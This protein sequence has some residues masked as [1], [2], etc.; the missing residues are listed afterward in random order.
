MTGRPRVVIIGGGFAGLGVAR[1]LRRVPV[2]IT[3][4]DR[5]NFHL[6]QPLLYQVATGGLSPAN[7]SAPLRSV[8]K[9]QRHTRVI[10][11]EAIDVDLP[12]R[13]VLLPGETLEY[14]TLVVATGTTHHYFGHDEWEHLA[15]GL[16]SIED[17]TEMRRR[18]L[19]AFETAER[20]HTP[21]EMRELLTFV[22]VGGGPTG[23]ELAGAIAEIA[24]DTLHREFRSINPAD[25][26]ILLLEGTDRVLPSYPPNLSH[27]ARRQLEQLGVTVR[28]GAMV[29]EI[30]P[31]QVMIQTHDQSET[32]ATRTVLWAA[33]VRASPLGR[34]IAQAAGLTPDRAG[35]VP[36]Q[37]DLTVPGYSQVFVIG[38]LA[39]CLD[40]QGRP[41]PG[42]APVAIQ[43]AGHVAR[44]IRNRLH[45]RPT[46]AFRYRD[47]GTMATIGRHRAVAVCGPFHLSG[48][49]AWLAWLL[50]HVINLVEFRDRVFVTLEWAWNYL[51]WNR[52]ARLITGSPAE[53]M[54]GTSAAP[55]GTGQ[56]DRA[57]LAS[58]ST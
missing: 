6:F 8:L 13:R 24:R 34:R 45:N 36:V 18:I 35:R 4:V 1:R 27:K 37:P 47:V 40:E 48:Y 28:T 9:R 38:D 50:I 17:A 31:H 57:E 15:P 19:L 55:V 3:L 44:T 10:L 33:G 29:R 56:A 43:Q 22:V 21:E 42:V 20:A 14:D 12:S 26:R 25:A 51:T 52:G 49:L 7:I 16:K 30:H 46:P 53:I 41:L 32:I 5:R 23:V 2:D 54:P 58:H 11:G 39:C